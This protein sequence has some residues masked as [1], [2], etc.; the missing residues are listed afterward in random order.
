MHN[1]F[2]NF[3]IQNDKAASDLVE[4]LAGLL[5]AGWAEYDIVRFARMRA[6][7][8]NFEYS[9]VPSPASGNFS[10]YSHLSFV[11]WLYQ[12]KRLFS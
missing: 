6:N 9:T 5:K 7:Y 1:Q 3:T 2:T 4:Q 12:N 10:G 11:R 8:T